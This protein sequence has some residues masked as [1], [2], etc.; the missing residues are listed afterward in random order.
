MA[1]G[2]REFAFVGEGICD[3]WCAHPKKTATKGFVT[4]LRR[5]K[6]LLPLIEKLL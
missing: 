1:A 6:G 5:F 4:N 3:T 2:R